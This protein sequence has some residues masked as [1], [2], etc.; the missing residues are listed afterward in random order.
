M[1][2]PSGG[3]VGGP[4]L[5]R[6]LLRSISEDLCLKRRKQKSMEKV[7]TSVGGMN[8]Q[9]KENKAVKATAGPVEG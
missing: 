6:S 4:G 3:G 2:W 1:S 8:S 5:Q 7:A 9:K